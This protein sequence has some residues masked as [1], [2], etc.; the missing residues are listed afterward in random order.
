MSV[1]DLQAA[2]EKRRPHVSGPARCLQCGHEWAAVAPPGVTWLE[3]PECTVEKGC[4]IGNAY[5]EDGLVWQCNCGNE[6]FL[7]TR[8]GPLCP[9]CGVYHELE[10][11]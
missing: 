7:Q 8:N 10:D 6:L 4:F 3:C 9:L 1:I 2:I 11:Q 5:P